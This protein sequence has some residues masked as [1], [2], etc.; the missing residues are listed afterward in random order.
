MGNVL[1]CNNYVI[2][3]TGPVLFFCSCPWVLACWVE[4]YATYGPGYILLYF[5]QGWIVNPYDD[6]SFMDLVK[7]CQS[8]PT[9]LKSPTEV[10]WPVLC[11][12]SFMVKVHSG[13]P[14]IFPQRF[15][16][17]PLL[18]HFFYLILS[19]LLDQVLLGCSLKFF[20]IWNMFVCH[21]FCM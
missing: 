18:L 11:W 15:W 2:D 7:L 19:L 12:V 5:C 13:V 10:V 20:H 3:G 21:T 1:L 9:M 8:L 16:L 14:W 17:T 6:D 4:L